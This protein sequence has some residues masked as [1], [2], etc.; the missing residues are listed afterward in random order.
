ME[1]PLDWLQWFAISLP[2]ASCSVLLVRCPCFD[3]PNTRLKF[4]WP[5][6]IWAFLHIGYRWES[7]LAIAPIKPHGDKFDRTHLFVAVVTLFTISL[8]CIEKNL[9]EWIGDMGIIAV[10]PLVAFFGTKILSKEDFHK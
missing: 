3:V 5:S 2:V 10:I 8:W 6:Q 9:E 1:P 4:T 7:D